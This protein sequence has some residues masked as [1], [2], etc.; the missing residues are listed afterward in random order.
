ML[1]EENLLEYE[2]DFTQIGITDKDE[3]KAILDF[4]Y[5]LGTIICNT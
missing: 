1:N 2:N 4:F 3:Q 5:T